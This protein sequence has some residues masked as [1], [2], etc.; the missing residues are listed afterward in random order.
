MSLERRWTTYP[1]CEPMPP[2]LP[3]HFSGF[4]QR[5]A[6]ERLLQ[7]DRQETRK[8]AFGCSQDGVLVHLA[9]E[10]ERIARAGHRHVQQPPQL[11]HLPAFLQLRALGGPERYF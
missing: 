5:R 6:S 7:R 10:I 11:L 3:V 1:G 9:S 4:G 8:T 2:C